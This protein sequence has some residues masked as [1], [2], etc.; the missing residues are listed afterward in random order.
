MAN[1]IQVRDAQGALITMRTREDS[2]VHTPYQSVG[3][4]EKKFRDSF[5]GPTIDPAKWDTTVGTGGA[6]NTTGGQL[7]LGSG[8][9]ASSET[10]VLSKETFIIPFRISFSLTLSQRIANQF[11]YVE[12]V[13]VDPVT[14][15][16]DGLHSCGWLFDATVATSAK[17]FVQSSGLAP[18]VSAA[19]T[20]VTTANGTGHFEIEPF[21][22]EA[23]FHSGVLDAATG[24]AN[25]YRRHQQIP[26]PN[27]TYKVRIRWLNNTT[28][29]A[30][31]TNASLQFLAVQDYQELTAEITAGR[32]QT[33]AGQAMAVAVVTA[34]TT[35]VTG[36]VTANAIAQNNIFFNDTIT[37][38]AASATF[39]GT[40][41]DVGVAANAVHRYTMF[42]AFAH[43][44]VAGTLRIECS[45]NNTDWFRATA[46]TAVAANGAVNLMVPITTRYYRAVYVNGAGA[47]ATFILNTSF[48]AA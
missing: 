30:S 32:G 4:V 29:P 8:N 22:D 37:P 31:N 5:P 21:A 18:L 26:D 27:A 15:I 3:S 7:V 24:R 1:N 38:L 34:P 47:Q 46:D 28:A 36:T 17:Y 25:S 6:A 14:G 13:S 12:A 20:V 9:V 42:N 41:R 43:S 2:G 16:P 33:S 23:W 45:N 35:T 10:F 40:S 19:S 39:T 48:T 11:F 44:N